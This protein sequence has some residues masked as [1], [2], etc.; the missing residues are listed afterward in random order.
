[1][2]R[3]DATDDQRFH[4]GDP[5]IRKPGTIVPAWWL[6]GVQEELANVIE[7]AGIPLDGAKSDQLHAAIEKIA[8]AA[9][10][11]ATTSV[12]G[13]IQLATSAEVVAGV[14][15]VKA[16]PPHLLKQELDKRALI[17]HTQAINTITGLSAALDG[18][19]AAAAAKI[20]LDRIQS[21]WLDAVAGKLLT[22]GAFGLGAP[23]VGRIA[24]M[25]D[26]MTPGFYACGGGAANVPVAGDGAVIVL[27]DAYPSGRVVQIYITFGGQQIYFRTNQNGS[28]SNWIF[29]PTA[30][31]NLAW[32]S[33]TGGYERAYGGMLYQWGVSAAISYNQS[34]D[35]TLPL[36]APDAVMNVQATLESSIPNTNGAHSA[37]A[38]II[39]KSVIRLHHDDTM[40][41]SR[42]MRIFWK[43]VCK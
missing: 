34:V 1:M 40:G 16:V 38:E 42:Q 31:S 30:A 12:A 41:E 3:I 24:D 18:L 4:A 25:D 28:F 11:Y 14:N 36:A 29:V 19:S 15:Q 8:A 26:V 27:R 22:V 33:S 32:W 21:G 5:T 2:K 20:P 9:Y 39:S 35:I 17:N 23:P 6:N 43:A 7:K 37:Y 10:A 13:L